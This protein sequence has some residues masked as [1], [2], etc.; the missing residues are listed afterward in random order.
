MQ[1]RAQMQ[2]MLSPMH[3][4]PAPAAGPFPEGR[5]TPLTWPQGR[6][7]SVR[8]PSCRPPWIASTS[9]ASGSEQPC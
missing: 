9:C 8:C 7:S 2:A 1:S 6:S 5:R 3:V 4:C